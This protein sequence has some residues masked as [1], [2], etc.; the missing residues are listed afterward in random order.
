MVSAIFMEP[1]NGQNTPVNQT[2]KAQVMI[3]N[4][5]AGSFTNASSTYYSA[6]QDLDEHGMVIGHTHITIQDLR[7][8][9]NPSQV[10]DPEKFI[11]FKAITDEGNGKGLLSTSI[12]GGIATPSNYRVYTLVAAATHEPV[13]MP[14]ALRGAQDD[15]VRFTVGDDE[16]GE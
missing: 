13:V 4:L 3:M 16:K 1:K 10:P 8:S 15:C 9:M 12:D 5:N 11:S 14:L 6:P 7:D 2:F